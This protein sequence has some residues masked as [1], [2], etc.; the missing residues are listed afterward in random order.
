[1]LVY[2]AEYILQVI[3]A[4]ATATADRDWHDIWKGTPEAVSL[5]E[6]I[7]L[8]HTEG[9]KRP[10]VATTLDKEFATSWP[11]QVVALTQRNMQSLWRDPTYI[12]SKVAL[13]IIAGLFIGFTFFKAKDSIQGTQNKLFVR[14]FLIIVIKILNLAFG[15]PYSCPRSSQ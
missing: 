6:E 12:A 8:I 10:P 4:G 14:S 1:M 3:G 5:Q 7:D 2:S 9:R 11:Y 15:S 13:N